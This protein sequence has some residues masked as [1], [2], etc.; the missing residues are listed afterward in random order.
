[1]IKDGASTAKEIEANIGRLV[2]LGLAIPFVHQFMSWLRDLHKT[3]KGRHSIKNK[4][5]C[6]KDL[7]MF[8][9]FLKIANDGISLNSIAFRR[10]T[11]I[12]RS[13]L[14]PAG[15]GGYSN[16][17][18]AWRWYQLKDLLFHVLNNLFENLAAIKLS[19][20]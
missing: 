10:P 13:D 15:L 8:L 4:N 12:Y 7:E 9:G 5:E 2:H 20:E 3:S 16:E 18:W 14:C 11:H 19:R 1:M 17:C 6:L